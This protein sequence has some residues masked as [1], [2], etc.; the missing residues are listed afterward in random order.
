LPARTLPA[1]AAA[2]RSVIGSAIRR[3]R[4]REPPWVGLDEPTQPDG[5]DGDK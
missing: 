5:K 3:R 4:K 2:A 1:I